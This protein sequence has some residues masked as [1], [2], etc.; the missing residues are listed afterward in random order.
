MDIAQLIREFG[1]P[2]AA[3]ITV[4]IAFVR[5]DVKAGKDHRDCV[6]GPVYRDALKQ[7]DRAL[8]VAERM[9]GV[10]EQVVPKRV[11]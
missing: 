11:R 6:P 2:L 9:T 10:A 5:G 8:D 4:V 3:L 1:L 7:R